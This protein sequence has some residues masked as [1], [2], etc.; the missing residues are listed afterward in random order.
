MCAGTSRIRSERYQEAGP[1]GLGENIAMF[2]RARPVSQQ[3]LVAARHY[4]S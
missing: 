1:D 2:I 4:S 3:Y